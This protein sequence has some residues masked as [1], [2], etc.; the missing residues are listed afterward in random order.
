MPQPNSVHLQIGGSPET[1][2]RSPHSPVRN[3]PPRTVGV[4]GVSFRTVP[5][6]TDR[7]RYALSS[8]EAS[9]VLTH[10]RKLNGMAEVVVV[11]TC[12]R[13][14]LYF[15]TDTS[16]DTALTNIRQWMEVRT[17]FSMDRVA[18]ESYA[19]AGAPAVRHLFRVVS[20]LDSLVPGETGIVS[21]MREAYTMAQKSGTTGRVLNKLFQRSFAVNKDLR[22]RTS[23]QQGQSSVAS[24]AAGLVEM[25]CGALK[26]LTA[27]VVGAGETGEDVARGL[28][29]HGIG[30]LVIANRGRE[31]GEA[32]A[33]KLA[34]SFVPITEI[35]DIL[36]RVDIVVT[37]T[38]SP[39][40]LMTRGHLEAAF[41][42]ATP[43][44]LLLLDLSMPANIFSD[45]RDFPGVT[46]KGIRDV[47]ETIEA[48]LAMR[49]RQLEICE[50]MLESHVAD[51]L[52]AL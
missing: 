22:T 17:Q 2:A 34:A 13:T 6:D 43:R 23:L 21:Q 49:R 41:G 52:I 7:S 15:A 44:P 28:N 10:L 51:F 9:A 3:S 24:V 37:A 50:D 31:R 12:N 25:T 47:Q 32:L 48:T 11:S 14:E 38:G 16:V 8:A 18:R 40:P 1:A 19:M 42:V 39:T 45:C 29:R 27:L 20:G 35:G 4:V 30:T 36:P 5:D 26:D 46:L 33:K